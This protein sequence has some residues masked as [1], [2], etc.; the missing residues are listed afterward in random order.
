MSLVWK[1]EC[2][3]GMQMWRYRTLRSV[4]PRRPSRIGDAPRKARV[5]LVYGFVGILLRHRNRG[6][7]E[8]ILLNAGTY[9]GLA[10]RC[11]TVT[12][13]LCTS[14]QSRQS[15]PECESGGD[16]RERCRDRQDEDADVGAAQSPRCLSRHA[17][18]NLVGWR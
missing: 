10:L 17:Q 14:V 6:S 2:L 18:R 9:A 15:T 12:V 7:R 8:G 3:S 5:V 16:K 4:L 13:S 1:P 11:E